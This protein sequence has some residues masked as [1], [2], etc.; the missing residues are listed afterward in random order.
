MGVLAEYKLDGTTLPKMIT[1]ADG[2]HYEVEICGEPFRMEPEGGT[3]RMTVYP[4]RRA[5]GNT[6]KV[7]TAPSNH[8]KEDFTY[9]FE[10][11]QRWYVLMK[12]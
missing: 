12:T 4:I 9:L 1:L 3:G 11:S 5:G 8:R 10:C 2:R 6:D 7:E